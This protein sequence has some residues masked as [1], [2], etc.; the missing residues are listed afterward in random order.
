M[1]KIVISTMT[2]LLLSTPI[3]ANHAEENI[4]KAD[5]DTHHSEV[6]WDYDVHGPAHWGEFGKTCA[7]GGNQSPINIITKDTISPKTTIKLI[8]N[9]STT[10]NASIVDNGHAIE[11]KIKDGGSVMLGNDEYKLVQFHFHG[12]SEEMINGKR[13]ELVAHMV[14]KDAN[15]KLLVVAVLFDKG[16]KQNK[17]VENILA[18]VG[19]E[20]TINPAEILPHNTAKYY[21]FTGSL[22][23]PP[24]SED[25][26]W[27]VLKDRQTVTATQIAT[28]RKHYDHNYRPIQPTNGR[29]IE[30]I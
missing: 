4:Q 14:H 29:V 15:G 10:T 1:R 8:L 20:I 24:C 23:T 16:S 3:F 12:R 2:A 21:K 28:M 19:K 9:E 5:G 27:I 25:V 6:H 11:V 17:A 26:Q 13:A 18:S 30:A 7:I 22:T